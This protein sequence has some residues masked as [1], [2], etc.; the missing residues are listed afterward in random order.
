MNNNFVIFTANPTIFITKFGIDVII[1]LPEQTEII[2]E[3]FF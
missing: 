2:W 1:A 3:Y